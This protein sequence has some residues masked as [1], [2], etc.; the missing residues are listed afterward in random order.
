MRGHR[1]KTN[2]MARLATG[3]ALFMIATLPTNARQ[4]SLTQEQ[5]KSF[6]REAADLAKGDE[7]KFHKEF[8]K[9]VRSVHKD[10]TYKLVML[11]PYGT[12][13]YVRGPIAS[14]EYRVAERVRRREDVGAVRYFGAH[15]VCVY[16]GS[17]AGADYD[18]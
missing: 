3:A 17:F 6:A 16:A 7:S 10:Y 4:R 14:Y 9:R 1:M 13:V 12:Q 8:S 5:A 15:E 2:S 18:K 11:S